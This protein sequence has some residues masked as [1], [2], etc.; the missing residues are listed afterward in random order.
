MDTIV[1]NKLNPPIEKAKFI[2]ILPQD[3]HAHVSLRFDVLGCAIKGKKLINIKV[4][5]YNNWIDQ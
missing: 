2:R 3:Y 5:R 1:N 4:Y